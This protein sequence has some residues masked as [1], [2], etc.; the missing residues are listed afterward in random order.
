MV[1]EGWLVAEWVDACRSGDSQ[2]REVIE[3]A[4]RVKHAIRIGRDFESGESN[5]E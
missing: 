2:L 1:D 3:K 4:L 5:D